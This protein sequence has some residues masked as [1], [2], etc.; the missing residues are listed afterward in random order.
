M[1][2]VEK[3]KLIRENADEKLGADKIKAN[4]KEMGYE[5]MG[6]LQLAGVRGQCPLL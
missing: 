2:Y 4:L 3:R 6:R 1:D 5:S